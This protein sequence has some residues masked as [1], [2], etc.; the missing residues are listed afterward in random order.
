MFTTFFQYGC[1]QSHHAF[2]AL[3]ILTTAAAKAAH[4]PHLH[5]L[6]PTDYHVDP[7]SKYMPVISCQMWQ[8]LGLDLRMSPET[9]KAAEPIL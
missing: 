6:D 9:T 4:P 1:G 8:G 2:G 5:H 7:L 3:K